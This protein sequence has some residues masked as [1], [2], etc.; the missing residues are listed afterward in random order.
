LKTAFRTG[1]K[2]DLLEREV[3]KGSLRVKERRPP[4]LAFVNAF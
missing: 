1:L 3:H 4:Y 2:A